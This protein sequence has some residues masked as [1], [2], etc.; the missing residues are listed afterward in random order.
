ME[1]KDKFKKSENDDG[2]DALAVRLVKQMKLQPRV[3]TTVLATSTAA[4]L[5]LVEPHSRF[6]AGHLTI[7]AGGI[8][9]ARP[10][11]PF[12]VII[13]NISNRLVRPPKRTMVSHASPSPAYIV[14]LKGDK[15]FFLQVRP[16]DSVRLKKNQIVSG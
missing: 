8:A 6:A 11:K 13:I 7:M 10:N 14:H 16:A 15:D 3:E 1:E 2:N 5:L 4:G 12:C 9:E